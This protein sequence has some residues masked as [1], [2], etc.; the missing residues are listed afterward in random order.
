MPAELK[1][2]SPRTDYP[3]VCSVLP[4]SDDTVI[5]LDEVVVPSGAKNTNYDLGFVLR[6]EGVYPQSWYTIPV[7]DWTPYTKR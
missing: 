1:T 7:R 6:T 3:L 2:T 4:E 5:T